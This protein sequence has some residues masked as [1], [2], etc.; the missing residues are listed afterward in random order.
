MLCLCVDGVGEKFYFECEGYIVDNSEVLMVEVY[1]EG[2]V[3]EV[4][5]FVVIVFEEVVCAILVELVLCDV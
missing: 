4:I 2:V 5:C 3:F 1:D